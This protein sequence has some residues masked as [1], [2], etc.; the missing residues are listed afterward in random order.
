MPV[1]ICGGWR[2]CERAIG[3]STSSDATDPAPKTISET[4]HPAPAAATIAAAPAASATGP[5]KNRPGVK[6]SPTASAR[7]NSVQ[8]SQAGMER[9]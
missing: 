7:A 5:R 9:S 4:T 6:I 1:R 2:M 8:S 3:R